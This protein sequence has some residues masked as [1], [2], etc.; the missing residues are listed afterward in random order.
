MVKTERYST[1]YAI[2]LNDKAID[3]LSVSGNVYVIM[4][5][6]AKRQMF[7]SILRYDT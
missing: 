1:E 6:N 3:V 4:T 2:E 5:G 7:L